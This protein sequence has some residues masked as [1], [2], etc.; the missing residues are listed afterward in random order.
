MKRRSHLRK[1]SNR[2][3]AALRCG[4]SSLENTMDIRVVSFAE[5]YNSMHQ[6]MQDHW[7]EVPFGTFGL[8][9]NL[10]TDAYQLADR[11]EYL[12]CYLMYHENAPIAYV[13]IMAAPMYKHKGMLS[14]TTDA[15]YVAPEYR[16]SG[17]FGKL[18]EFVEKDLAEFGIEFFTISHNPMYKGKTEEFLEHIGYQQTEIL[19]TKRI[20][21]E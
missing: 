8:D 3:R 18:I 14:A 6:A 2:R 20:G 21:E 19:F 11:E 10:D 15:Y 4:L 9:F 17:V 16:K 12:R 1:L 7:D 5:A 13:S